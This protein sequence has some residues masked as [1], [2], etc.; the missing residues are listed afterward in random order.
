MYIYLDISRTGSAVAPVFGDG[1]YW[2]S[3]SYHAPEKRTS[4]LYENG[5][6]IPGPELTFNEVSK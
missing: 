5:E 6:F 4:D 3:S 2:V 1:S